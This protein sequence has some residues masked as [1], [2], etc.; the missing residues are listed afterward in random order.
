MRA[1]G[2]GLRRC[3][4]GSPGSALPSLQGRRLRG[5]KP[6]RPAG[7]WAGRRGR[8]LQLRGR[9]ERAGAGL[10]VGLWGTY[11]L[12][13][14]CSAGS[15]GAATR[16]PSSQRAGSL[17]SAPVCRPAGPSA[18]FSPG[19]SS[20]FSPRARAFSSLASTD[21]ANHRDRIWTLRL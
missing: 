12:F 10:A 1:R 17:A 11:F 14:S 5:G 8:G 18:R 16:P 19:D 7:R 13:G 6:G 3:A 15:G 20:T 9:G 21:F 4:R 2:W